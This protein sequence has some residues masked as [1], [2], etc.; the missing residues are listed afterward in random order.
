MDKMQGE[1]EAHK[2]NALEAKAQ[3][4][5]AAETEAELRAKIRT[6]QLGAAAL[7]S[8]GTSGGGLCQNNLLFSCVNI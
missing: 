4:R 8:S 1:I 3:I 2:Y 7:I 6:L 5:R